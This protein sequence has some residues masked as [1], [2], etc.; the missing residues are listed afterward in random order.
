M[1]INVYLREMREIQSALK[2]FFEDEI[3]DEINFQNLIFLLE[4]INEDRYKFKSFLYLIL[5]I[6]KNFHHTS[7]LYN[8]IERKH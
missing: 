1:N 2:I 6:A 3:N 4:D 8:K 5:K 7:N